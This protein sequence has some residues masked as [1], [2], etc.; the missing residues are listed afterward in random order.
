MDRRTL[1]KYIAVGVLVV[2]AALAVFR[3]VTKDISPRGWYYD[4]SEGRLYAASLLGIPPLEGIGGERGDGVKAI[5][6][7]PEGECGDADARR[8]AYLQT[9]TDEYKRLKTEA[10]ETGVANETADRAFQATSTL[11]KR[12][13]DAEWVVANSPEGEA[14]IMEFNTLMMSRDGG[15]RWRPCMPD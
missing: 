5:V 6:I 1:A 3:T 13:D 10:R 2:F 7:A 14:I 15:V 11:V 4:L 9:F 12:V 8:I